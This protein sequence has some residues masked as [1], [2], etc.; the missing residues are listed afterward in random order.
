MAVLDPQAELRDYDHLVAML[1]A[2][3]ARKFPA[4]AD[5][6][7]GLEADARGKGREILETWLT[8]QADAI[9]DRDLSPEGRQNRVRALAAEAR[10]AK[11]T[12]IGAKADV[13]DQRR[14][15]KLAAILNAAGPARPADSTEALRQEIRFQAIRAELRSL[16]REARAMLLESP[17]TDREVVSALLTAPPIAERVAPNAPPV[18]RPLVD[19]AVLERTKLSR[20][21]AL[22]PA[23][24]AEADGFEMLADAYRQVGAFIENSIARVVPAESSPVLPAATAR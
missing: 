12:L 1:R 17:A 20:A 5:G 22:N 21:R 2:N 11:D 8:R 24:A 4:W 9:V 15:D 6:A 3:V 23:A 19:P 7:G 16:P 13:L 14:A 18:L 10:R